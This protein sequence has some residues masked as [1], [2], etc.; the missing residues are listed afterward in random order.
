MFNEGP[1]DPH[2]TFY[3]GWSFVDTN[4][5]EHSYGLFNVDEQY[6]N[7]FHVDP[8]SY[9]PPVQTGSDLTTTASFNSVNATT[10]R[11]IEV[12]D[13]AGTVYNLGFN[14]CPA[15][16]GLACTKLEAVTEIFYVQG[17]VRYDNMPQVTITDTLS[18]A[19]V[20]TTT[21]PDAS[22]RTIQIAGQPSSYSLTVSNKQLW[23]PGSVVLNPGVSPIGSCNLTLNSG[24][25]HLGYAVGS[26]GV[27]TFTLPN[28]QQYRFEYDPSFG[29]PTKI[30]YP[31]GGW[32]SYRW[33]ENNTSIH[34]YMN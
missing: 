22:A 4:A 10:G 27:D 17:D 32:I 13:A 12:A 16:Q 11:D 14:I 1:P 3:T 9:T 26:F 34:G 7:G 23:T 33:T 24:T 20:S 30:I 29:V 8:C 15:N 28:G 2:C 21:S 31:T 18:R 5:T 19:L 25:C 6:P